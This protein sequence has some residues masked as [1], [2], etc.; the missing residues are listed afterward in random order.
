MPS[1]G[2]SRFVYAGWT[3]I[4]I[5]AVFA[6]AKYPGQALVSVLFTLTATALLY[7]GFRRDAIF[8]DAFIGVFL[9]LGFWLKLS[10]RVAFFDGRFYDP[11]GH[12]DGSPAAFDRALIAASCAFIGLLAA[13]VVRARLF[14][15]PAGVIERS[16]HG[17]FTFYRNHRRAVLIAYCALV[18]GVAA[19]NAYLGIYQRGN[20]PRTVLPYGLGGVYSWLLLFGLASFSAVLLHL[21]FRLRRQTS[22]LALVLSLLE[23]FLSNTSL[24]SRGMLFNAGALG[25][26][27][28]RSLKFDG[29]RTSVRFWVVAGALFVALFA[30]SVVSVN[31]LRNY[32][33]FPQDFIEANRETKAL[34]LD[35]WVGMEALMSVSSHPRQGWELWR[36]AWQERPAAQLSF[37]DRT[38]IASPYVD[39]D[40]TRHR[41][42]SLPGIVA[43]L[44]YPGSFLFL[45]ACMAALGSLAALVEISVF[46]LG[47]RNLILCAL[48]AQVVAWR[49]AHFGFVPA[50]SYLLFGAVYLNLFLIHFSDRA[51]SGRG[52]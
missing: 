38:F 28:L 6:L 7:F 43:F 40:L 46:K 19:S 12:F 26:G 1:A 42:I 22:Y 9:W 39:A 32:F 35:R 11:V 31:Y 13:R 5:L 17:L 51:L 36:E 2:I 20:V 45:L 49:Y 37:Y 27:V 48:L 50:Q 44:F 33:S 14:V 3:L 18:V 34:I 10:V 41:F 16:D 30:S 8:F 24:L 21:E 15:Y 52:K 4:G 29:L 25:Y 23:T 47:G